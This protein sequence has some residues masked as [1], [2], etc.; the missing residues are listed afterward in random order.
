MPRPLLSADPEVLIIGGG[1]AGLFC[2]YFLRRAGH[3]V[4]VVEQASVGDPVACSY[5]NTGFVANGGVPLGGPTVLRDGLRSVLRPDD[6]LALPPTWD[7]RRLRWLRQLRRAGS[8]EQ[9]QR[10]AAVLIEMKRRSLRILHE[11]KAGSE[12]ELAFTPAGVV[13]AYKSA[14]RFAQAC[15]ALPQAVANGVRLRVL[16]LEELRTLEPDTEFAIAG[17]LYNEGGGFLHAPD[18]TVSLARTLAGMGVEVVENCTVEG[19]EVSGRTVLG[20]R[21]TAGQVRPRE[22]VVAAGSWSA[23]LVRLLDVELDLQPVRGYTVS[24]RRPANA[25]KGPV[26]LVEGTV[27]VRALGDQLRYGGDLALAG[28]DRSI[29]RRRVV[30][31]LHTVQDHLPALEPTE[32]VQVWAGLRP[33][34]PDSL[35]FLGRAP[36]FDNLTVAAGHGHN[37][38]GLAPVGGQL[39]AEILEGSSPA[40]DLS[41]FRLDR[42]TASSSV[43]ASR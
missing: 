24:V 36:A 11:L 14:D 20:V 3:R 41:P 19:F 34:T 27:A 35:P 39:I 28:V 29:S 18:V 5:G 7:R 13:Q 23:A 31:M 16:E 1:V 30:R 42:Y 21:T 22:V 17:A 38:M 40:M 25:P 10:S 32:T 37:G 43:G 4:T 26:L 15:R 6:L 33:C 9:V 8:E 12:P 2:A